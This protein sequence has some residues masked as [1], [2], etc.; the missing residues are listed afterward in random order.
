MNVLYLYIGDPN[1]QHKAFF[2]NEALAAGVSVTKCAIPQRGGKLGM[3]LSAFMKKINQKKYDV[4][5]TTEYF[6]AFGI[7]LRLKLFGKKTKH[8]VYGINQSARLLTFNNVW[9]DCFINR[10]FDNADLFVTHSRAEMEIFH[11]KHQINTDKIVFSHWG[12]DLPEIK[13]D[14]F[15]NR[16]KEYISFVGRNNRD[17]RTF[18][19]SLNG[20]NMDGVIIT[21]AFNKPDFEL[22]SNIEIH[23]DLDMESCL[24]CIK[25]ATINAVLV[26]D[27][28]RG[29]GHITIV[30]SMLM[31]KPQI[32]SDVAVVK[33]YFV[34]GAHGLSVP[35]GDSESVK[36]AIVDLSDDKR[37]KEYGEQAYHYANK[38]FVN[39]TV[40][41]RFVEILKS[42]A[43]GNKPD[44]CSPQWME[45]YN[46]VSQQKAV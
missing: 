22:P 25:H 36:K 17:L 16:G 18:C 34:A 6:T 5:I 2:E 40:S 33:D 43:D 37:A 35:I 11:Q 31:K 13:N 39:Q 30:A 44:T 38:Y 21:S 23:Y 20:M 26:N 42:V 14:R 8:I 3:L 29:A 28:D 12:F 9:F 41:K 10:T 19:D 27:D 45:D 46:L 15:A 1:Q 4:V 7:N 32:V 24:S